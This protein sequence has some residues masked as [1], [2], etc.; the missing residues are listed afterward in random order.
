MSN[1]FGIGYSGLSA[2][3]SGLSTASNNIANVNTPG[4]TRQQ[5]RLDQAR[6]VQNPE[7]GCAC[8]VA[9]EQTENGPLAK[10]VP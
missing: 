5:L 8:A 4:Y 9:A 3:Q 7:A 2:A 1:L 6:P 10:S